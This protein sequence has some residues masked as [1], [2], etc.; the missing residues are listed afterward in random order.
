MGIYM[1][2]Y[3]YTGRKQ[4]YTGFAGHLHNAA[5]CR[6]STSANTGVCWHNPL[7]RTRCQHIPLARCLTAPAINSSIGWMA[8]RVFVSVSCFPLT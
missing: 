5:R 2:M 8:C 3:I 6:Q 1:Y 7:N 4:H